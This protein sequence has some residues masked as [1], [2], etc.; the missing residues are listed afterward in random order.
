M[1]NKSPYEIRLE[2]LQMAKEHL[3]AAFKAQCDFALQM[4]AALHAA[5]KATLSE[6]QALMP[7]TYSVD[8]I[9][10]KAVELYSFVLRKD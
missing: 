6:I 2:V 3:D 5:N 10:K 7:K 4:G 1:S 9:T 8:D